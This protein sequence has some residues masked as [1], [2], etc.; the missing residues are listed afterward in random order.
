MRYAIERRRQRHA[1]AYALGFLGDEAGT[2]GSRF[3][4]QEAR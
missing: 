3:A 2:N 4:G 1:N